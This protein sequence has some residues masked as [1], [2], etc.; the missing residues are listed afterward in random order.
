MIE[1]L[2]SAPDAPETRLLLK[3][4]RPMAPAR[5][6]AIYAALA[7]CSFAVALCSWQQGNVFAPLF[8]LVENVVLG[9]CLA[10]VWRRAGRCEV[11]AV[12]PD[13]VAVRGLPELAERF[14]GHPQFVR[15][16]LAPDAEGRGDMRVWL[17]S[18][19]RRVEVG[20]FLNEAERRSLAGQLTQVLDAAAARAGAATPAAG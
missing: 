18:H 3:P 8:A 9:I 14:R 20:A 2:P 11:I 10:L 4:N 1:L 5:L 19:G 12:A 15:V 6:L 7:C 17:G 13:S 16:T